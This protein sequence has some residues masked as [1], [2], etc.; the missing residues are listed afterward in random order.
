M[1]VGLT[2]LRSFVVIAQEGNIGRAAQRLH[3]SQPALSRQVQQL[4]REVGAPLLVR[5]ARGVEL[6]AAGRRL[7]EK[8]R[9][10]IDA[11]DDALGVARTADPQGKLVVGL[12]VAGRRHEWFGLTQ[13]YTERFPRV[14]VELREALSEPLQRQVLTGELDVALVLSPSRLPSLRYTRVLDEPLS[15]WTREDDPL[16]SRAA[17][18]VADLEGR[19]I[20]LIG[21]PDG[22]GAGFNAAVR[23]VFEGTGVT[24]DFEETRE[25]FP[26]LAAARADG[27]LAISVPL[28]YPPGIVAVPLVPRRTMAFEVVHRWDAARAAVR[29]FVVF[30]GEH[31]TAA[32]AGEPCAADMPGT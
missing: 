17:V 10:A 16:A 4:E 24:P 7:L 29:A 9:V 31:L 12:P 1:A 27:Y 30:A 5:T 32:R 25:V 6:T 26:P 20:R 8:A 11:A 14:E 21:G 13:A 23:A 2:H 22:R 3:I 15:V 28:D 18:D 19:T